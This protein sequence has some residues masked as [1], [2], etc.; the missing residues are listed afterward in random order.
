MLR[1]AHFRVALSTY[2]NAFLFPPILIARCLERLL[3]LSPDMEYRVLSRPLNHALKAIFGFE[4]HLIRYMNLPFGVSVM[5]VAEKP[6]DG[7]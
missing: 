7:R 2:F 1:E 3:R 5:V 4:R 6:A